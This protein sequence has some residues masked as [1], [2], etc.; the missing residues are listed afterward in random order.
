MHSHNKIIGTNTKS[1]A[2]KGDYK[3]IPIALAHYLLNHDAYSKDDLLKLLELPDITKSI[4]GAFIYYPEHRSMLKN[5]LEH[6]RF[7]AGGRKI[8]QEALSLYVINSYFSHHL[9]KLFRQLHSHYD[10]HRNCVFAVEN[11][12]RPT[13]IRQSFIYD[14]LRATV[15]KN[16]KDAYYF[17]SELPLS[18]LTPDFYS[19]IIKN[20]YIYIHSVKDA[21]TVFQTCNRILR[22]R[23]D[24]SGSRM[25]Q[26]KYM[27]YAAVGM[28]NG[29]RHLMRRVSQ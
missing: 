8:C 17:I 12:S 6:Y 27:E 3:E 11:S 29:I 26:L 21:E 18:I 20:S 13:D 22:D 5:L 9:V 25:L 1:S 14:A 16:P 28:Q 2:L 10:I 4:V 15:S 23:K 19:F 24:I 7:H